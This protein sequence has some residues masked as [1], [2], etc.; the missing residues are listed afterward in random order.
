MSSFDLKQVNLPPASATTGTDSLPIFWGTKLLYPRIKNVD[1]HID[2]IPYVSPYKVQIPG[3][4]LRFM[5]YMGLL[6]SGYLLY[7]VAALSYRKIYLYLRSFFNAGKYLSSE[8]PN[9]GAP[10]RPTSRYYAVIYGSANR[11]GNAFARFLADKGFNLILIERDM[12][13]LNDIEIALNQQ[14]NPP[15]IHKVVLNKF[16]EDSLNKALLPYKDL[17]IKLFVNC[18]NSKRKFD[19]KNAQQIFSNNS[20]N[21]SQQD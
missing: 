13:P 12:Q 20:G 14:A 10:Q 15:T 6:S 16:E 4:A 5:F 7:K 21:E 9:Q 3:Y 17:P 1:L 18:K 19:Q 2:G 8:L 11:P